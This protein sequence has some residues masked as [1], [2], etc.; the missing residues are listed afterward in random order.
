MD[1]EI[2][3]S[4]LNDTDNAIIYTY[5]HSLGPQVPRITPQSQQVGV[6]YTNPRCPCHSI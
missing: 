5:N 4:P 1:A 3:A 6:R 2:T